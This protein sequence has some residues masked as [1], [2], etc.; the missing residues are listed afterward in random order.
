MVENSLLQILLVVQRNNSFSKAAEELH[1]TQSAISQSIKSL[2]SK[3]G[4]K[5]I[6]R[7]GKKISLTEEGEKIAKLAK[8]YFDKFESVLETINSSDEELSGKIYLGTLNGVGKSWIATTMMLLVEKY[9][10]LDIKIKMDFPENLL[11]SFEKNEINCLVLPEV[12]VPDYAEKKI[13]QKEYST[14]VFPKGNPFNISKKITINELSEIPLVMFEENDPLFY[15]WCVKKFKATPK[16][17]NTRLVV[18]S[19][20]HIL[21]AVNSGYGCAVVPS[22]VLNRSFYKDE[23][24]THMEEFKIYNDSFYFAFH[25]DESQYKKMNKL[26]EIL[27]NATVD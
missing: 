3:I 2:E 19:F 24:E 9:P 21:Q 8:E 1:V 23:V 10:H 20:R 5:L 18:N 12:L 7:L 6:L 4:S 13:L 17:T 14:L 15:R 26:F 16:K 11:N 27:K 22:H 25:K